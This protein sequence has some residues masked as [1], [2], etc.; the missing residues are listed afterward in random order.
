MPIIPNVHEIAMIQT[1]FSTCTKRQPLVRI[2]WENASRS[3]ESTELLAR[4][5]G[6]RNRNRLHGMHAQTYTVDQKLYIEITKCEPF[7]RNTAENRRRSREKEPWRQ[8]ELARRTRGQNTQDFL[9]LAFSLLLLNLF[10]P[11]PINSCL[12]LTVH[13]SGRAIVAPCAPP[14]IRA[15]GAH[16]H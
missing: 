16:G 5:R 2:T 12:P 1:R 14:R 4:R 13:I 15:F 9:P 3:S 8:R 11:S 10:R 7:A 6:A